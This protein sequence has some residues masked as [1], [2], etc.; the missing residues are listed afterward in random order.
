MS[1][2]SWAEILCSWELIVFS[3][4]SGGGDGP[5]VKNDA[6]NAKTLPTS[7]IRPDRSS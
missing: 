1:E 2:P 5:P 7:S 3:V 6:A 4:A